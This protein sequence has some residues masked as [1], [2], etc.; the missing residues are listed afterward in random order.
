MLTIT[1]V[2][3]VLMLLLAATGITWRRRHPAERDTFPGATEAY[4]AELH[5]I[6]AMPLPPHLAREPT[7]MDT[8]AELAAV[9]A[10][11]TDFSKRVDAA[12][13]AF[14]EPLGAELMGRL[15]RA[16]EWAG[17]PATG[18]L[19]VVALEA[20]LMEGRELVRA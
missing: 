6:A 12:L 5:Q 19:D 7:L 9:G 11:L 3:G 8:H 1:T 13:W 14:A 18:E 17:D 10:A 15:L 16:Q 20:L 2:T 4:A